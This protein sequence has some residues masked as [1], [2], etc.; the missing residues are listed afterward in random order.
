[1]ASGSPKPVWASQMPRKVPVR[2]R[3]LVDP[4]QRDQGHLQGNHQQ[5]DHHPEEEAPALE[6][7]PGE[8]VGG[9]CG[10]GDGDDRRRDGDD[11]AVDEGVEQAVG[12]EHVGVV[13]QRPLGGSNGWSERRS[14]SRSS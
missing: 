2:S 3:R 7:H 13:G 4:Q 10:E 8:P 1:M 6:P 12:G 9:E 11:Q 5:P 14:T